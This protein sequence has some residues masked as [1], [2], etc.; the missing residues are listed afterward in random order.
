MAAGRPQK[1]TPLLGVGIP[2]LDRDCQPLF[3]IVRRHKGRLVLRKI[4]EI[5]VDQWRQRAS[6][7]E[8]R[9]AEIRQLGF[10]TQ[11]L[12]KNLEG[13]TCC[14]SVDHSETVGYVLERIGYTRLK[15]QADIYVVSNG[16]VLDWSLPVRQCPFVNWNIR[17]RFR[18]GSQ[19]SDSSADVDMTRLAREDDFAVRSP[20]NSSGSSANLPSPLDES[21]NIEETAQHLDQTALRRKRKAEESDKIREILWEIPPIEQLHEHIYTL[22]DGV[23][24]PELVRY[25]RPLCFRNSEVSDMVFKQ[26]WDNFHHHTWW[27]QPRPLKDAVYRVEDQ[28][29]RLSKEEKA[30]HV[31]T[32]V[33]MAI[34][35]VKKAASLK[36]LRT[37][38]GHRPTDS[39][40][41]ITCKSSTKDILGFLKDVQYTRHSFVL[42]RYVQQFREASVDGLP[43]ETDATAAWDPQAPTRQ[44]MRRWSAMEAE[45]QFQSLAAV[46]ATEGKANVPERPKFWQKIAQ[47]AGSVVIEQDPEQEWEAS[48]DSGSSAAD[49]YGGTLQAQF[50]IPEDAKFDADDMPDLNL[51]VLSGSER[52]IVPNA[53]GDGAFIVPLQS[54]AKNLILNTPVPQQDPAALERWE[55]VE[56]RAKWRRD[57]YESTLITSVA[58]SS[59]AR[60]VESSTLGAESSALAGEN[61]AQSEAVDDLSPDDRPP[62]DKVEMWNWVST[63]P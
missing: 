46:V 31:N 55:H 28:R 17:V 25:L 58:E 7:L 35:E 38:V 6:L 56:D 1:F 22:E 13:R 53:D 47:C 33:R 52:Y 20:S 19:F 29:K 21:D 9:G 23:V 16:I 50:I 36:L 41:F 15:Y 30:S 26:V 14:V 24:P 39:A 63:A 59:S 11:I 57:A 12:I 43:S 2:L 8:M 34:T 54:E 62:P 27:L 44:D 10:T 45:K 18:G 4:L 42:P 32:A 51:V 37:L 61:A 49:K 40:D 5:G 48:E 3:T 60:L